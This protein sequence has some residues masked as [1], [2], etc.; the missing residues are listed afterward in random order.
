MNILFVTESFYPDG[1][2][3]IHT[4]VCEL[5]KI[6]TNMG[7]KVYI[8]TPRFNK[9]LSARGDIEGVKIF[10]YNSASKGALLFIRRPILSIF[11][12]AIL[13]RKLRKKYYFDVVN[14]HSALPAFGIN[15]LC[16]KIK[17]VY[18]FHAS[19]YQE[20]IIQSRR[21]KYTKFFP[22]VFLLVII[23][24]IENINLKFAN[25]IIVLS[26]FNKKQLHELY[27]IRE[28]KIRVIPGG[29]DS[30]EYKPTTNKKAIRNKLNLPQNKIIFFT[31]R[32]LVS[33]MGLENLLHAFSKI[34]NVHT[35]IVLIIAGEGFL[36]DKMKRIILEKDLGN[37][38]F[39]KGRVTNEQLKLYYQVSDLFI[40]PTEE[41]EGFGLVTLEALASG[42]PV[43][44]TPVGGTIEI[45]NPFN[46][47]LLFKDSSSNSIAEG[48]LRLLENR[49]QLEGLQDKCR[50][51][52]LNK[53][54]WE[55][56]GLQFESLLREIK[57]K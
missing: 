42:L 19:M 57:E 16:S 43:I 14:F 26:N 53:Y 49:D 52:V 9:E 8:I 33:R 21:K 25:K 12:S 1:I 7:H 4:Y 40:L 47:S 56:I 5:A 30:G 39:L 29:V 20:V 46:E 6:L 24:F 48:I 10:R 3:G 55:K 17:K 15:F 50:N 44:A 31:A 38:V 45:L 51:Y 28:S 13:F 32:R 11:N 41:L 23:K 22:L 18:T 27:N 37:F 35:N 34:K 2:G 54:T 36:K